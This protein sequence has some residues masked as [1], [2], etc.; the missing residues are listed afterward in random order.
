MSA[1]SKGYHTHFRSLRA[2]NCLVEI[3]YSTRACRSASRRSLAHVRTGAIGSTGAR[4]A[5]PPSSS[6]SCAAQPQPASHHVTI[7]IISHHARRSPRL[8]CLGR[9]RSAASRPPGDA[10]RPWA[11]VGATRAWHD[12]PPPHHDN[13]GEHAA[14]KTTRRRPIGGGV[15]AAAV[16]LTEAECGVGRHCGGGVGHGSGD[17]GRGARGATLLAPLDSPRRASRSMHMN[18]DTA[19]QRR[20]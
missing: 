3:R 11:P 6:I 18:D 20:Q 8:V 2:L 17:R 16:H 12:P 14:M 19:I 15:T 4:G 1:A 5:R 13:H 7:G 9:P 10:S